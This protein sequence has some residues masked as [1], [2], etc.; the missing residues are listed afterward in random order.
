MAFS[1]EARVPFLDH[2]LVEFAMSLPSTFKIRSG[3]TKR[4]LRDAMSGISPEK[5]RWRTSKLGYSTPEQQWYRHQLRPRIEQALHD[6]VM[7]PYVNIN[8]A[9]DTMDGLNRSGRQSSL[10]WQW[11]N[12]QLW[13]KRFDLG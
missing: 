5:I 9:A 11:L 3:Y 8:A 1:V 4:V 12:L 6:P 2:R 7:Q 13:L 10:P